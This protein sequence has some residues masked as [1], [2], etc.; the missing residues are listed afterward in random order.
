MSLKMFSN[1]IYYYLLCVDNQYV[2]EN[3]KFVVFLFKI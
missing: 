2:V 3:S 1:N